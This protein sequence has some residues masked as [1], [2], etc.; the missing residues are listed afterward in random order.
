MMAKLNLRLFLRVSKLTT[1]DNKHR[2]FSICSI[3][4]ELETEWQIYA[5]LNKPSIALG[6]PI[7]I[8]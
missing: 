2:I 5:S 3:R 7:F 1:K 4:N 8:Q 6:I